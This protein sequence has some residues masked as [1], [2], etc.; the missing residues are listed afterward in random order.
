MNGKQTTEEEQPPSPIEKQTHNSN[1]DNMVN[2]FPSP[3][4]LWYLSGQG[5]R[6]IG[7]IALSGLYHSRSDRYSNLLDVNF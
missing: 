4:V 7:R 2:E 5:G 1:P 3:M 6:S